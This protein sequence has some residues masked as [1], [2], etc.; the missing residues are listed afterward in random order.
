VTA[1]LAR[2]TRGAIALLAVFM[3]VFLTAAVYYLLGIGETVLYRE[4]MQDAVDAAAL[5][6]AVLHA[7]GMNLIALINMTMAALLAVLVALKLLETVISIAL[8]IITLW[9]FFGPGPAAAIPP[10]V[11]L[12]SQVQTAHEELRPPIHGMLQTLHAAG[13]ALRDVVPLASVAR[14]VEIA[15]AHP[16][17]PIELA[18]VVPPRTMLPTEDGSFAELCGRAGG[19]V[20]DTAKLA[21]GVMPDAIAGEVAA[22]IEDLA[23]SRADWFC[24]AEGAAAPA[25]ERKHTLRH[26]RLPS[27]QRCQAYTPD[28]P[29]YDA[30]LHAELCDRAEL[31]EQASKP[32]RHSGDCGRDCDR[33]IYELRAELARR[34]CAPRDGRDA[35]QNF[36]WQQRRFRRTYTFSRGSWRVTS[37]ERAEEAAARYRARTQD[38][39][40]CGERH[41]DVDDAWN[42]DVRDDEGRA[43]PLC[44]NARP[45]EQASAR[46][47]Q[48]RTLEHIEVA[49]LFGCSEDVKRNYQ[50]EEEHSDD[51]V[52]GD[53][54]GNKTPQVL[55]A[56]VELGEEPFQLRAIALG[57][58]PPSAPTRVIEVARW[59]AP[60]DS[61]AALASPAVQLGRVALAQAEYFYAVQGPEQAERSSF[62][63]NMRWQ[64]RLRRFRVEDSASGG[65]SP[66][67]GDVLAALMESCDGALRAVPAD[68]SPCA[69]LA[70]TIDR[71][72]H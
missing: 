64:A 67:R 36:H 24:G 66:G 21:L 8:V 18:S 53:D 12:R 17:F 43:L 59:Q 6:S 14:G 72:V 51:S 50:L 71:L 13:G 48:T 26:P 61:D 11:Q 22:V 57:V 68:A 46:D 27:R 33:E 49:H 16:G 23:R 15:G 47:G 2:D 31:D 54:D 39:R 58:P 40:P 29:G 37:D 20:G 45:P 28:A 7:R 35:L 10:L 41:A 69:T 9:S 32:E 65:G 55:A 62:L 30:Q 63:W 56:D 70:A 4:R 34:D 42:L 3:A 52:S 25:S 1:A 5:S 44:T 19:Y 38:R 60:S